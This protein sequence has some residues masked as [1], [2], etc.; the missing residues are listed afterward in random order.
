MSGFFTTDVNVAGGDPSVDVKDGVM[1][2]AQIRGVITQAAIVI[3]VVE[4]DMK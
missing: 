3:F 1:M 2:S 4:F